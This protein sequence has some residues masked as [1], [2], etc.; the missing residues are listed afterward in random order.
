[1]KGECYWCV[2]QCV[3]RARGEREK[4]RE[5]ERGDLREEARVRWWPKRRHRQDEATEA[6]APTEGTKEAKSARAATLP[7]LAPPTDESAPS[8]TTP[9]ASCC[10]N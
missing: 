9:L 2:N 8:A 4:E 5:R 10:V 7:P 1:M 3:D 6:K